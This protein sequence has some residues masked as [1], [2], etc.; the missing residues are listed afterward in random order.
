MDIQIVNLACWGNRVLK[1]SAV[2]SRVQKKRVA[3][4]V[5]LDNQMGYLDMDRTDEMDDSVQ[6]ESL[7]FVAEMDNRP[8]EMECWDRLLQAGQMV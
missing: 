5:V 7:N 4:K 3:K 1:W 8:P 2:E 6:T